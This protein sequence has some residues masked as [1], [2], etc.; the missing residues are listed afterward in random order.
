MAK[1]KKDIRARIASTKNTQQIT[2]AMKM[3]SAAK[4]RRAQEQIVNMRPY[5]QKALQVIAN[6]AVTQR[7]EHA[8]LQTPPSTKALLLV[9]ILPRDR[10]L[11]GSFNNSSLSLH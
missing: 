2:R 4:L 6:V 9:V 7:V 1:P 8:L 5:A 11:C 3:V 10:G